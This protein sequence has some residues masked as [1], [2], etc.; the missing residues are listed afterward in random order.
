MP[1]F[2]INEKI[3]N[4]SPNYL[5]TICKLG[6]MERIEGSDHL[7][8]TVVNG[9]TMVISDDMRE[10]DIVVYFPVETGIS[11]KYLSANNLYCIGEYE[12]NANSVEVHNL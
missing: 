3:E 12:R 6:A 9:F 7:M 4:Y 5:A 11:E 10:G 8:R 1:N 2:L